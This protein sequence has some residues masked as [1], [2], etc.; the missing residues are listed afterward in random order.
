[1]VFADYT[2]AGTVSAETMRAEHADPATVN[3]T[4][5]GSPE[6]QENTLQLVFTIADFAD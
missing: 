5:T 3:L 1:M 4:L 2:L 6:P